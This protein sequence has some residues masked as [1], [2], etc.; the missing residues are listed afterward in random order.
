MRQERFETP[1]QV[2]LVVDNKLGDVRLRAH[3][4]ATT[5]VELRGH[6]AQ[7]DEIVERGPG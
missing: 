2:D 4:D 6:G 7:G 3:A 1:G 5:E